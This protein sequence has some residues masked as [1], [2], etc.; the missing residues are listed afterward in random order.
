MAS[1]KQQSYFFSFQ[2]NDQTRKH[3]ENRKPSPVL[4]RQN[5]F[6][7]AFLRNAPQHVSVEPW[8]V[9]EKT[10][11]ALCIFLHISWRNGSS[12]DPMSY[13][14]FANDPKRVS[15]DSIE[16]VEDDKTVPFAS[17]IPLREMAVNN[18]EGGPSLA[19]SGSSMWKTLF[20]FGRNCL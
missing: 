7:L 5:R 16:F 10:Q 9:S 17:T 1:R 8:K 4:P 19:T 3:K 15:P 14:K 11:L 13:E 6:C 20:N 18:F 2:D 12:S